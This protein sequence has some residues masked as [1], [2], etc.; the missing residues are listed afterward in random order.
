MIKGIKKKRL[1]KKIILSKISS[2]DIFKFYM[3]DNNWEINVVT[4]SPFRDEKTPSFII[5]NKHGMDSLTYIDFGDTN[6]KG[7]CFSFVKQLY[8]IYNF[9]D[10][11]R[12]IDTDFGLGINAGEE[13]TDKYKK[14][15]SSYK[16]PDVPVKDYSFIQV[17]VRNFT[18]EELTYWNNYYQD[19]DDLKANNIF[20]ISEVYLNKKR[21]VL[22][23]NELRFGYL[24]DGN[25]KIYRPFSDRKWKWM[26]NNVPITEM[27]GKE[28]IKDCHTAF[29]T[30][31]KKDYMVMKKL[32]PT[33]CA[34]QNE[35]VACFSY[36][37][38][39][40]IKDNSE[41]QILSFDSDT[42]GVK[43]SINITN[44]FGFDYCNV[45]KKYLLEGINDWADLAKHH[46]LKTIEEY[47]ISK[48]IIR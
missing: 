35:G 13:N 4:Y 36:D 44:M 3:P 30:K 15:V 9:N 42:T 2:Y 12:K 21:I 14:I 45:P 32:F 18:N 40:Y 47:L 48:N 38:V 46:G 24:Y 39:K 1:S 37:N 41:K 16:K 11:L 6:F 10:V 43:N 5:G 34:V 27:D 29:I 25:W 33:V 23:N 7:D 17:K 20:S 22:N 31:S 19:I 8:S 26:P 28:D